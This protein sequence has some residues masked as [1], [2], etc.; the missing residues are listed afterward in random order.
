MKDTGLY[1]EKDIA[2]EPL[3]DFH[4]YVPLSEVVFQTLKEAI[5]KGS[6]EPGL[7][8][9]ENKIAAKLN[10]SR[11]PVREAL[12]RL[13]QENMV[14]TLPGRRMIVS[15]PTVQ[16]VEEIYEIRLLV[17]TEAL[18]RI[19]PQHDSI[20][21]QLEHCLK[22]ADT[23]LQTKDSIGLGTT[24]SEFH[25]ILVS[26]LNNRR[27]VQ[28]IDSLQDTIVRYRFYS[29]TNHKWAEE[30]ESEHR[31]IVE[32]LKNGNTEGAIQVLR[33]HLMT[34]KEVLVSIISENA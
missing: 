30:S 12:R 20:I 13:E 27:L 23:Q 4:P 29:L 19:T 28:L 2:L 33:K 5:L 14:T 10:V 31:E 32:C 34:A 21:R 25:S 26:A 18:R 17:E 16:D 3:N 9:S 24:N 11:T 7:L 8:L 1:E 22:I 6:L 15:I